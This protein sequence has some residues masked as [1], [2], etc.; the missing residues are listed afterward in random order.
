MAEEHYHFERYS[1]S[2]DDEYIATDQLASA[3][4][5]ALAAEQP[6][7]VTGE[8]GTGKTTLAT[9]IAKQLGFGEVL[10]FSTRSEHQGR[11]CLYTFDALGRL[12]DVQAQAKDGKANDPAQYVEL[13]ELGKAIA[14]KGPHPRV[15][16][17]D[18]IDKAS[19]DFPNDL[20]EALDEMKFTVR[21]T[22]TLYTCTHRPI[23]VITSNN[24]RQLPEPFLRRCVFHHIEFPHADELKKIVFA[25]LRKLEK[26]DPRW[27]LQA[28]ALD[29]GFV[30]AALAKFAEVREMPLH[31]PPATGE[32][33]VWVRILLRKGIGAEQ[34]KNEPLANLYPGALVKLQKDLEEILEADSGSRA[35]APGKRA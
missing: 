8:P 22:G 1:P 7:V 5:A 29:E 4:N 21:E 2:G 14:W 26:A 34:V 17:I 11:D 24:E 3:V 28:K 9:S 20:L 32:L 6:L 15:V 33:L 12:Y 13:K 35:P 31:K 19:R 16:L 27:K 30:K 25:H 23:V 18:E 10:R